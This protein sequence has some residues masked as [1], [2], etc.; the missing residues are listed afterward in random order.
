M[1]LAI[2]D[3]CIFIDLC[4]LKLVSH[5]FQ[6]D[7]EIH[8]S[9]GVF[10]ELYPVQQEL[11]RAFE[12]FGKLTLHSISGE[13]RIVIYEEGYPRA[14]SEND[15]IVLH[16]ADKIDAIVL[17][18]DKNVRHY[19][20]KKAIEYHGMLWIFDQLVEAE[21]ITHKEASEKLQQLLKTNLVYRNNTELVTQMDIRLKKWAKEKD[22]PK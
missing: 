10:N 14:L 17:S 15:K 19:A 12:S 8:T 18:S 20:K 22:R 4:D 1:K 11:L 21:L 5:F 6:L 3:A 13:D 7:L 9:T 2:T 16:L